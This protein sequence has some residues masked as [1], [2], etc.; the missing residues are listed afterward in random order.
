[1]TASR[2]KFTAVGMGFAMGL[3]FSVQALALW[4][5][6]VLIFRGDADS[7]G[8][9][10]VAYFAIMTGNTLVLFVLVPMRTTFKSDLCTLKLAAMS[11]GQITEPLSSISVARG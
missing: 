1:M 5:G 3:I 8:N 2:L 9:L 6:G 4:F 11:I 10:F 7:P